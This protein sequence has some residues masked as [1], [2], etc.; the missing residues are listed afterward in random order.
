MNQFHLDRFGCQVQGL[1]LHRV[2]QTNPQGQ[3]HS[4]LVPS[5]TNR[6]PVERQADNGFRSWANRAAL[7]ILDWLDTDPT[8]SYHQ[9]AKSGDQLKEGPYRRTGP[10]YSR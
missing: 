6:L 5:H 9:H 10:V 2:Q 3:R 7:A 8:H 1:R 4:V